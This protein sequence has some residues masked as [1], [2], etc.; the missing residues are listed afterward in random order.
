MQMIHNKTLD[1]IAHS[2]NEFLSTINADDRI[3][4]LI[5]VCLFIQDIFSLVKKFFYDIGEVFRQCLSDFWPCILRLWTLADADQAM[6]GHSVKILNI[7]LFLLYKLQL[8]LRVIDQCCKL[9]L[10]LHTDAV[11]ELFIDLGSDCPWTIL[12]HMEKLIGFS[13]NITESMLRS[14]RQVHNGRQVDNLRWCR[15]NGRILLR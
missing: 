2:H 4:D 11:A 8:L 7:V 9:L 12:Q 3:D 13:M 14:F 6:K 1:Q 15:R 10:V 5:V